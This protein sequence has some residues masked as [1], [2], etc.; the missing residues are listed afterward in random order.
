[1]YP[2]S[3]IAFISKFC[4]SKENILTYE[5][6]LMVSSCLAL[7]LGEVL[8]TGRI[9]SVSNQPVALQNWSCSRNY[10]VSGHEGKG[11]CCSPHLC[12]FMNWA[13]VIDVLHFILAYKLHIRCQQT[14]GDCQ[15]W[16]HSWTLATVTALVK[17]YC[18]CRIS[19]E[20]A[21]TLWKPCSMQS[22]SLGR[23]NHI[24]DKLLS[25]Q[26]IIACRTN[27]QILYVQ[28][29]CQAH[30]DWPLQFCV[31]WSNF[32]CFLHDVHA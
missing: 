19:L 15:L 14:H 11:C 18:E 21:V 7:V 31:D 29:I 26:I 28:Y 25:Q 16:A 30:G 1:M 6:V 8:V 24:R 5:E 17:P 9:C 23:L 2:C 10:K 27:S 32:P 4:S 3:F 12:D 22:L 20:M 13:Q